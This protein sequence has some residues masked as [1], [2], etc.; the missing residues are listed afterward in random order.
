MRRGLLMLALVLAPVAAGAVQPDEMLADPALEARARGITS[1][2]RC[3]VCQA[4]LMD[5]L[6][7]DIARDLRLLVRERI[8]AGD[9]R[10]R[11]ARRSWWRAT[12]SSCCSGRRSLA[13]RAA[14]AGGTGDLPAGRRALAFGFIRRRA[15]APA[16]ERPP[17]TAEEEARLRDLV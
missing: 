1:E 12:A 15:R 6:N 9:T 16:P 4:E 3:V 13:E 11:G 7:A 14:L 2:L 10:R 17:L 5:E 8:V